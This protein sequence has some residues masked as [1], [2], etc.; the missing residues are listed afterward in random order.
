MSLQL[1]ILKTT[2]SHKTSN[3]Q[4]LN[5]MSTSQ[6]LDLGSQRSLNIARVRTSAFDMTGGSP[7]KTKTAAPSRAVVAVIS[8]PD[9]FVIFDLA[10]REHEIHG[11]HLHRINRFCQINTVTDFLQEASRHHLFAVSSPMTQSSRL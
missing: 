6:I 8:I 2:S 9:Y 3:F 7:Q 11:W 5:V 10:L 4:L 1:F